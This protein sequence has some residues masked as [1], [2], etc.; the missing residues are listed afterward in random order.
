MTDEIKK[1]EYPSNSIKERGKTKAPAPIREKK[2]APK[3]EESAKVANPQIKK[4][5]SNAPKTV[6][7]LKKPTF[8][9]RAKASVFGEGA[10]EVG[11]YVFWDVLIPAVKDTLQ[12]IVVKGIEM[13]L[14]GDS[15]RDT[16]RT[17]RSNQP[18]GYAGPIIQYGNHYSGGTYDRG[19]KERRPLRSPGYNDRLSLI[20]FQFESEAKS[21]LEYLNELLDNYGSVSIADY[22]EVSGLSSEISHTDNDWGWTS[23]RD[24]YIK[25]SSGGHEIVFADP[26]RLD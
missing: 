26:R 11:T 25:R 5:L 13:L 16:R 3:S 12:D 4:D 14:Y 7:R 17:R 1:D 24:C 22:Y 8:L 2:P 23:L 19:R 6:A 21:V 10:S 9:E 18:R 20:T 15:V